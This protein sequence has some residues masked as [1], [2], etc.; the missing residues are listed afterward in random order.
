M[1]YFILFF[2]WRKPMTNHR[3]AIRM[4]RG[5]A[6]SPTERVTLTRLR[7][8]PPVSCAGSKPA[9]PATTTR[10]PGSGFSARETSCSHSTTGKAQASTIRA[11]GV[12]KS[13]GK[14]IVHG[15][16]EQH[17]PAEGGDRLRM[18]CGHGYEALR[19]DGRAGGDGRGDQSVG[20]R[21]GPEAEGRFAQNK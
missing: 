6:V 18:Q 5:P 7:S 3:Q 8:R 4:F 19:G 1:L 21:P 9:I 2:L 13:C 10:F 15:L 11:T 20:Q 14:A 16:A 17:R 12:P